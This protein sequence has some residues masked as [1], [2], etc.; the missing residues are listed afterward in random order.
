MGLEITESNELSLN[1]YNLLSTKQS[2]RDMQLKEEY[3]GTK[4]LLVQGNP[5]DREVISR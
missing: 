3:R 5:G 4:E 2:H 1:K